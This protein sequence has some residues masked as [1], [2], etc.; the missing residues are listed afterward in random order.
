MVAEKLHLQ[1]TEFVHLIINKGHEV[2][3]ILAMLFISHELIASTN[4]KNVTSNIHFIEVTCI[5]CQQ[6]KEHKKGGKGKMSKKVLNNCQTQ[7]FAT[8]NGKTTYRLISM[9]YAF[10]CSLTKFDVIY[11]NIYSSDAQK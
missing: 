1:I 2:T 11:T 5:K 6:K 8:Q 10:P 3:D 7:T 4:Q 9:Q